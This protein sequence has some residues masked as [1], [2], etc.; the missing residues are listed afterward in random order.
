MLC[1]KKESKSFISIVGICSNAQYPL[2]YSGIKYMQMKIHTSHFCALFS[3]RCLRPSLNKQRQKEDPSS[4]KTS[5]S[6]I[7]SMIELVIK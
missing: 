6:Q 7:E 4:P 2:Y 3:T 1:F 5:F